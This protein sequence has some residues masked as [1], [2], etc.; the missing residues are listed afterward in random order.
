MRHSMLWEKLAKQAF[1][2]LYF[3][4]RRFY[5][6]QFLHLLIPRETLTSLTVKSALAIKEKFTIKSQNRVAMIQISWEITKLWVYFQIRSCIAKHFSFLSR[7]RL[8]CHHSQNNVCWKLVTAT[9]LF[10][11]LGNWLQV[12]LKCQVQTGFQAYSSK[13]K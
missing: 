7:V 8:G 2:W 13:K 5:E 4:R 6:S 10:I 1:R 11:K 9:L 3:F 12:S